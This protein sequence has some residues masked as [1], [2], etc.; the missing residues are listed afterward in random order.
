VA[1][2]I[3]DA[4]ERIDSGWRRRN[5]RGRSTWT[6]RSRRCLGF[7]LA[8]GRTSGA[9][10]PQSRRWCYRSCGDSLVFATARTAVA[11]FLHRGTE[12][13]VRSTCIGHG[14]K[15]QGQ[16]TLDGL[17]KKKTMRRRKALVKGLGF[18]PWSSML[19]L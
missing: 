13:Q 19:Y 14:D 4:E 12:V 9:S 6:W 16:K 17:R 18:L 10:L 3:T 7:I 2:R 11:L 5:V 1:L 15:Q 8:F